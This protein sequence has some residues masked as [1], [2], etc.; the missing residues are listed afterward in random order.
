MWAVVSFLAPP[1]PLLLASP[2][3]EHDLHL[4]F[5]CLTRIRMGSSL[6]KRVA[7]GPRAERP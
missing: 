4:S 3:F 5:R 7:P 1:F 2:R 6:L